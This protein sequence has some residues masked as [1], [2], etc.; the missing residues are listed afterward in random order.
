MKTKTSK[1]AP[2]ARPRRSAVSHAVRTQIQSKRNHYVAAAIVSGALVVPQQ[3]PA[4]ELVLD[5]IIVTATKRAE[6]LQD[7]PVSV[8]AL[9]S[10]MIEQLGIVDFD[11]YAQMLP[12]LAFKSVGPGTATLIMRGASDGGDGNASGSQPSVGL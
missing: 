3:A 7:I 5:E 10:E 4:Q 11:G 2:I 12:T 6:N 8:T 1:R 9:S